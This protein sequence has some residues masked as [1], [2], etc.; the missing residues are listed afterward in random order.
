MRSDSNYQAS[1]QPRKANFCPD[2]VRMVLS[3]ST[4]AKVTEIMGEPVFK[5]LDMAER[6]QL[7]RIRMWEPNGVKQHISGDSNECN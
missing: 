7:R 3:G 5:W 4:L 2:K 1:V 6:R